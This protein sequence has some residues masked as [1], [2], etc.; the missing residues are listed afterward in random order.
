MNNIWDIS[1]SIANIYIEIWKYLFVVYLV[2]FLIIR[3]GEVNV[4]EIIQIFLFL[5]AVLWGLKHW[6]KIVES[7]KKLLSQRRKSDDNE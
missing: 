1:K 2:I 7:I 4:S 6:T 3:L 5:G